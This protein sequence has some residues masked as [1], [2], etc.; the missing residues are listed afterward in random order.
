MRTGTPVWTKRARRAPVVALAVIGLAAPL[1]AQPARAAT[2][3]EQADARIANMEA[4]GK[5][6]KVIFGSLRAGTF[7]ADTLD[8]ARKVKTLTEALPTWFPK[9]SGL[10]DPGVTKSQA[11]PAVWSDPAK[12]QAKSG[13]SAAAAAAL[14]AALEKNDPAV[15]APAVDALGRSCKD[16]HDS[17][18]K[19][20]SE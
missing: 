18:R 6:V 13:A 9:G 7:G 19:P 1:M 15:I 5:A 20:K 16:C 2:P 14:V 12:F 4:I 8:A 11:L 3:Q 17:F 10:E